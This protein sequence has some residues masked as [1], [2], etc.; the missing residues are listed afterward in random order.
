MSL[1]PSHEC[2]GRRSRWTTALR[3]VAAQKWV[4]NM[5]ESFTTGF[6]N[7]SML[8]SSLPTGERHRDEQST[9]NYD[10]EIIFSYFPSI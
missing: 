8:S 10:H 2:V 9:K 4:P 7:N 3:C 1:H 6:V 5:V